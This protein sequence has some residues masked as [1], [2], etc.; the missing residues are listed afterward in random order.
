MKKTEKTGTGNLLIPYALGRRVLGLDNC[1]LWYYTD[2]Y[3]TDRHNK[4]VRH[5]PF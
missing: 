4:E 1:T 2:W 3:N 5:E